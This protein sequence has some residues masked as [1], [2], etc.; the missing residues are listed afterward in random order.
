MYTGLHRS[1]GRTGA[2][3]VYRWKRGSDESPLRRYTSGCSGSTSKSVGTALFH[4]PFQSQT[5]MNYCGSRLAVQAGNRPVLRGPGRYPPRTPP[6]AQ[7]WSKIGGFPG[8]QNWP[9]SKLRFSVRRPLFRV[10]IMLPKE[11]VVKNS[12]CAFISKRK[13]VSSPVI[14]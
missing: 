2:S 13:I 11:H 5:N 3:S 14:H 1:R 10:P 9:F 7:I 12:L 8:P 4:K 6:G